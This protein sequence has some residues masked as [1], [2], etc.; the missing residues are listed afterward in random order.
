MN[1]RRGAI[2]VGRA[3]RTFTLAGRR[4]YV[5]A[6]ADR[7][8]PARSRRPGARVGASTTGALPGRALP[9]GRRRTRRGRRHG[10]GERDDRAGSHVDRDRPGVRA[11]RVHAAP[12]A[13]GHPHQGGVVALRG[14]RRSGHDARVPAAPRVRHAQGHRPDQGSPAGKAAAPR[15]A[16]AV[17]VRRAPRPAE[18]VAQVPPHEPSGRAEPRLPPADGGRP[19]DV[20]D[21]QGDLQHA[22]HRRR[23]DRLHRLGG[24]RLLR[25]REGRAAA[26][27]AAHRRDHRL[28]RAAR[29]PGT[30]LRRLGRRHALRARPHD[31]RAGLDVRRGR[32]G[33]H[34][35]VHQLVRGQRRHR[36]RRH[37]V[38]PE[39]QLLH[40]RARP[41]RR[42][43]AVALH[44][45]RPDVVAARR[46]RRAWPALHGQQQPA[47]T[48]RSST[49]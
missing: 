30:R 43:R 18:P 37:A 47:R 34:R 22:G 12:D 13:Q 5:G 32:P 4:G 17:R 44:D 10:A 40:L 6:V 45:R 20:P 42:R 16:G 3:S 28:L 25:D 35:R 31:G 26:L 29:R 21:R 48:R 46:R 2:D 1:P 8:R 9:H 7:R 27:V 33:G 49:P 39:R 15:H 19:L 24:S 11:D 14:L 41:R 38:R 23:R 36:R